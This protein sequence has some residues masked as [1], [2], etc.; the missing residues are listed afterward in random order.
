MQE[1]GA[2]IHGC[3]PAN[4]V[5]TNIGLATVTYIYRGKVHHRDSLGTSQIIAPGAVNW[6]VA[7]R[8]I[9]HSERAPRAEAGEVAPARL[10]LRPQQ[11]AESRRNLGRTD[12][13]TP[14]LKF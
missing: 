2:D 11:T 4:R 8:G 7:G 13:K 6:M 12:P 1:D 14:G 3:Q 10:I 9:T 5:V